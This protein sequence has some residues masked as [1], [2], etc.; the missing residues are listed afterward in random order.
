MRLA[1]LFSFLLLQLVGFTQ[2]IYSRV[3]PDFDSESN[4]RKD[5]FRKDQFYTDTS[6]NIV[7]LAP[8]LK[9]SGNTHGQW[10]VGVGLNLGLKKD[11]LLVELQGGHR[12]FSMFNFHYGFHFVD[13]SHIAVPGFGI[14]K[15][16]NLIEQT[17]FFRGT[18]KY[19]LNKYFD[20]SA[21]YNSL[22]VGDGYRSLLMD[23]LAA[24]SPFVR[25]NA[26][27][28]KVNYSVHY[29]ALSPINPNSPD[30]KQDL[31][32]STTHAFDIQPWKWIKIN[33]FESVVWLGTDTLNAR[34][35]DIA[36][37][38]PM[39]FFRP[40]EFSLGSN[41]NALLGGGLTLYPTEN[42][43]LYGQVV[44][45]EFLLDR[46]REKKGWWANKQ[47]WQLGAKW[48]KAFGVEGL[49]LQGEYNAVRP[50][51]YSH[52]TYRTAYAN[53]GLS[54]AH[55]LGSNFSEV[56][57]IIRFQKGRWIYRFSASVFDKGQN[58]LSEANEGGNLLRPQ[59]SFA[60]EFGNT[61]GQGREMKNLFAQAN[62]YYRLGKSGES[63]L[64]ANVGAGFMKRTGY[65]DGPFL[66]LGIRTQFPNFLMQP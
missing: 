18:A 54:R 50:F 23:D 21:G 62:A 16:N 48:Q 39:I 10:D 5:L 44:I 22:F 7:L 8:L 40:V 56:L 12:V 35:Y 20:V 13:S 14:T 66:Q 60:N 19:Q 58:Y 57:G 31:S 29:T 36:Y 43:A 2:A 33:L 55:F 30:Q 15:K 45:D 59:N 24:P 11:R 28:W 52:A 32:F 51:T 17:P 46:V 61:L 9:L 47:G 34:G 63:N 6:E 49:Y 65:K 26:S 4:F 37:L 42:I 3:N 38:N 53:K 27:F 1:L 41:D 25:L 64:Y